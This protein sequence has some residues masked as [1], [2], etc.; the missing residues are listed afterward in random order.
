M[1]QKLQIIFHAEIAMRREQSDNL[2]PFHQNV[3]H[4]HVIAPP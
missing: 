4:H 2:V 3:I 1:D